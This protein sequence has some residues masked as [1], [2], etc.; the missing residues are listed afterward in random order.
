MLS[1][2]LLMNSSARGDARAAGANRREEIRAPG[3]VAGVPRSLNARRTM[4]QR[5]N[6]RSAPTPPKTKRHY[7]CA[8]LSFFDQAIRVCIGMNTITIFV[9]F[10]VRK[11][12]QSSFSLGRESGFRRRVGRVFFDITPPPLPLSLSLDKTNPLRADR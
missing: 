10:T 12:L 11:Q 3:E 2:H 1:I 4:R 8:G 7:L 9:L 5:S 6:G